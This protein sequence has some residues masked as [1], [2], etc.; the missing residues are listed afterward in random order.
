MPTG[1][2]PPPGR[3]PR[4]TNWDQFLDAAQGSR[5]PGEW[6]TLLRRAW[7]MRQGNPQ[8]LPYGPDNMESVGARAG[9]Y[10]S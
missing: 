8:A 6:P 9:Q 4:A 1:K 5:D 7:E 2:R 10:S 3:T